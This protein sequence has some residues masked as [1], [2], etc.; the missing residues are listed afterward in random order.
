[1]VAIISFVLGAVI[2]GLLARKRGGDLKDLL[3][4]GAVYGIVFAL[5][6]LVISIVVFRLG[7][8]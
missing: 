3:Q 7:W 4:Y 5:L 2:G 6:A 1:M 8:I